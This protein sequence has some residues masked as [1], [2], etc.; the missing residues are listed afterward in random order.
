MPDMLRIELLFN[1][2][3]DLWAATSPDMKGLLVV[4]RTVQRVLD[5]LPDVA[6]ELARAKGEEAVAYGWMRGTPSPAPGFRAISASL[7]RLAA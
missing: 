2:S 1:E 7:M 6:T 4:D 5:R 3:A